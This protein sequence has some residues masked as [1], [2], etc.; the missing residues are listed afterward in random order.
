MGDRSLVQTISGIEPPAAEE[1][2]AFGRLPATVGRACPG[3]PQEGPARA[4][5]RL[6]SCKRSG[7][8][9]RSLWTHLGKPGSRELLR[10]VVQIEAGDLASAEEDPV[11]ADTLQGPHGDPFALEGI[12]HAAG[13]AAEADIALGGADGSQDVACLV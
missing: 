9:G 13:L 3:S 8:R 5:Q 7:A 2:T 12:R 10:R 4:A 1:G 6:P 11:L